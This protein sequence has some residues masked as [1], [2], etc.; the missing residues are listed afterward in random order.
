MALATATTTPLI[1]ADTPGRMSRA[2]A[3]PARP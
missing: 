1:S 2:G 3:P